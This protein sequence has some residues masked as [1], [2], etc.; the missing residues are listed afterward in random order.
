M[1]KTLLSTI[2]DCF[3]FKKYF[4]FTNILCSSF[5]E[6]RIVNK[7]SISIY[8]FNLLTIIFFISSGIKFIKSKLFL[9]ETMK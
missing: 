2:N 6:I 3:P 7:A 4:L 8:S 5:I 9:I 1:K